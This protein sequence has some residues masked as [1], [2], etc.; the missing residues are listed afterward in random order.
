MM[1]MLKPRIVW[2]S[3]V[4]LLG[5]RGAAAFGAGETT[6][7]AET[8]GPSTVSKINIEIRGGWGD[9]A[10]WKSI[11]GGMIFLE[12]G[13]PF[14]AEKL[15]KSLAALKASRM[16]MDIHVPDPD[17][18]EGGMAFTFQMTPVLR[19][20][21][22]QVEGGFPVFEKE[23]RNAMTFRSGGRYVPERIPAQEASVVAL[24]EKQGYLSP[25]VKITA[26]PGA[27]E[28]LVDVKVGID[29]G[30][31]WRIERFDIEGNRAF[32]DFRLKLRTDTWKKSHLFGGIRRFVRKD[33]DEDVKNLV[34][35][36]R[37]KGYA[38][39]TII[40]EVEKDTDRASVNV[41]LIVDEG[42]R[43]DVSFEGNEAY[44]AWWTLRRDLA[45][46]GGNKNDAGLKKS[47]RNIRKRYRSDGYLQSKVGVEAPEGGK[48]TAGRREI[49]IVIDEG[50]QSVVQEIRIE[51]NEAFDDDR[52]QKQMLTRTPGIFAEGGYDPGRLKDDIGAI[53]AL[54]LREGYRKTVVERQM[55]WLAEAPE[56]ASR[57]EET[58]ET[59]VPE[60]ERDDLREEEAERRGSGKRYGDLTL[61]ID[62]GVQTR[63]T[64]LSVTGV[65]AVPVEAVREAVLLRVGEPFREYL[66][67]SDE[68]TITGIIAEKGY[69]HIQV[70][71]SAVLS[72]D[73]TGAD[74][75]YAVSEGRYVEMGPIFF[76]GNFRTAEQILRNELEI[77]PGE[78][79]SAKK[80]LES[81]RNIQ[82]MDAVDSVR[83]R[84]PGLQE[85]ADTVN[86]F[87]EIE[88]KR[89][90][91]I[92]L[93]LGYDTE[94]HLFA[95]AKGGDRNIFGRNNDLRGGIEVSQIG[96]RVDGAFTEPRF[97]QSR[98]SSTS[99]LF[100][101]RRE[102]FNQDFGI[103]NFGVS[104]VFNRRILDDDLNLG[105]A[106]RLERR[107][108]YIRDGK[109]IPEG[110][111]DLY[112]PR[113]VFVTTPSAVYNTTD[114]FA[115]PTK[116][117]YAA[118]YLDVSAGLQ[119]SL[120]NFLKYRF[121]SR[122]YLTPTERLT[123]AL[124]GRYGYI[125]P[126]GSN[127][128]VPD[129]QLFYLG[130]TSTVRG[131]DENLL[132]FD[133]EGNSV[134]GEES[135]LGNIEARY[136]LGMNVEMAA[137][138][139]VGSVRKA[140]DRGG[141]DDFRSSVG[142]GLRY[143]TPIGAVGLMYGWKLDPMAG[144]DTGRLHFSIGY[145]F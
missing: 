107:E 134:G 77:G 142:L 97:W 63:V 56:D 54:Y 96:Y 129:D 128:L 27:K 4:L 91:W 131:F 9:D 145:T 50:P 115:R 46:E 124:R 70:K 85:Q 90:Y 141:V 104:Q 86:L 132:R 119:E 55:E 114:S 29:K 89:P 130:G 133:D 1:N 137:F 93:S 7:R 73:G 82:N 67:K 143:I 144:E 32:S 10:L 116:G 26:E 11:A 74:V 75:V 135:L 34:K 94:R 16:F 100:A 101:E 51:G 139:D 52:I 98:I 72:A 31:Y 113:S 138:Y 14:S 24:F 17:G 64:S 80:I 15:Q 117:I 44:W 76:T 78:P 36:Y 59:D 108:Q 84:L 13:K 126:Y 83:F 120:D 88:E 118:L 41:R 57:P 105:L 21:A 123:F 39:A 22:I 20:R 19:V 106:F 6:V 49:R 8:D 61:T 28:G 140:G 95:A 125:Y 65:S 23:G 109:T 47:L 25:V 112:T 121:E 3:M 37:A 99:G 42:P 62:E 33:L 81:Q 30:R 43:Y 38:D 122:Y 58:A 18:V 111:E 12:E 45:L 79:F 69:P 2:I 53:K 127:S 66:L 40:A 102:E 60:T 68:E 5:L 92:E 87:M 48:G 136:D 71:G 35:F 110:E 103:R